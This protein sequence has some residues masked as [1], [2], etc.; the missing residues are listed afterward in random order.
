M[1]IWVFTFAL[2]VAFTVTYP[3]DGRRLTPVILGHT[4]INSV[5][6]PWLLLSF[7]TLPS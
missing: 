2:G 4:L 7:F 3:V 1:T 6:E 5:V